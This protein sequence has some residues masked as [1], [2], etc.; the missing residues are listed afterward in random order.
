MLEKKKKKIVETRQRFVDYL[1]KSIKVQKLM[2]SN[3]TER[4]KE[5]NLHFVSFVRFGV[6]TRLLSHVRNFAESIVHA[7]QRFVY[8]NPPSSLR[9]FLLS[10]PRV[11]SNFKPHHNVLQ[12]WS[13]GFTIRMK[14]NK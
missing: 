6:T 14:Q 2:L 10:A 7:I 13:Q 12:C 3:N 8:F 4:Q 9:S 1:W 11:Y 5:R